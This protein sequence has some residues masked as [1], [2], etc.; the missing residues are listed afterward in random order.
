VTESRADVLRRAT[1]GTRVV[2]LR[3]SK[4][5]L[6]RG[7]RRSYHALINRQKERWVI[8]PCTPGD[9]GAFRR[10]HVA[11]A[12]RETRPAASWGLMAEWVG[13]GH[14]VVLGARTPA[15]TDPP[16]GATDGWVGFVGCERGGAWGYYGHSAAV[17]DDVTHAL[18]WS[19]MLALKAQGVERFEVGWQGE[20]TDD[21]GRA[22]EFFR[23][24][25]GG[26]D[27]PAA[28]AEHADLRAVGAGA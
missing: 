3:S 27:V 10:L 19:A 20:A 22:I 23:R 12:G 17:V 6:W 21:K 24:G 4:D 11:A 1:W 25:F 18:V 7:V 14:L 28:E 16:A 5:V 8:V 15:W 9:M 13:C 2:N 26:V